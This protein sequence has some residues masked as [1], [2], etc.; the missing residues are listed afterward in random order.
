MSLFR[1]LT[2]TV[3]VLASAL[4][5]RAADE[6]APK[7]IRVLLVCGGCCHDY[8]RQKVLIAEGL[9]E[10]AHIEVTAVQQGGTATNSKIPLYEK[11]D[12]S[13]GY[14]LVI[15]DECFSDVNDSQYIAGILAPHKAGLPAV[16]LHC[17]MHCYRDGTDQWF[18]FCGVTSRMHGAGYPHEVLNRDPA[19]PIMK[20]FGPAWANPAGELYWIEK[21]WPTAH[22]LASSKN[23]EN[24]HDEVCVWTNQFE[25]G[26]VFGTTLG[27]H[28]E[29]VGSKAYLDM[30]TRG[31]L[32]AVD[33]LEPR[34]LK[35]AALNEPR[36]VP[37]NLAKGRPATASS[38][39]GGNGNFIRNAFD[40]N[41]STR[42]CAS[43]DHRPE[44]LQVDLGAP[45][46]L[47]AAR[48]DWE[49][50]GAYQFRLE[51]SKDGTTWTTIEDGSKNQHASPID[52]KFTSVNS[53]YVRV[54][55]L[56]G[57]GW[58]SL[59]EVELFGDKTE[60]IDPKT[61]AAKRDASYFAGVT[62]PEGYEAT[63]FAAPPAINYLVFVAAAPNGD[64]YASADRNGSIDREKVRGC[65]YRLRDLDG[66]GRA[67]EIK[68][69]VPDVDSPRG[70]VFDR[71]RVYLM[72]PPHLSAFIDKDGDGIADEQKV[73]VKNIAF[74]FK[75]RPADHTSNGV[76]LGIDGWL[77]LAI[78]D[79]GFL[80]AEGTDGRKL[81]LRG[82]GVVRVRPDGTGLELYSRGTRNIL[83]ASVDPLLN[84]FARDNTN[85]GG[86][87]D[88]RLHHFTGME[89][90]GYPR[91]FKNFND[92]TIAPLADYGG[93]SGCGGLYLSEPGFPNGDGDAL[94]TADWGRDRIYRHKMTPKGA[95]FAADQKE[96]M[97][98]P[99]V[100][101]LDVDALGH[102]YVSSW[103]GATFTFAGEEVGFILRVTPKGNK[104]DPLPD[105]PKLDEAG[106]V[107]ALDSPS[108]RRRL[109][110]QREL[111]SRTLN[112][113]TFE[114][115]IH[116]ASDGNK[117]L[118]VRVAALF[119]LK[120]G[121]AGRST[122][123]I[124]QLVSDPSIREYAL[125]ALTDRVDELKDVSGSS[126][127]AVLADQD[128]RVRRQAA[129]SL[130]RLGGTEHA[131]PLTALL[132]DR[133]PIVAHTAIQAL[134][135]LKAADA[136][137]TVVD[138]AEATALARTGAI[139]VLQSLHDP[140]I[141]DSL[142]RRLDAEKDSIRR[143]GLI[144]ALARLDHREGFWRGD[145][146]GTR[147]DTTG[148]YYQPEPW[149]ASPKIEAALMR[150]LQA[151]SGA[152]FGP[153]LRELD[154][155]KVQIQGEIEAVVARASGDPTL[156][157][158]AVEF[159]SRSRDIPASAV[160]F[161][162]KAAAPAKGRP[163]SLRSEATIALLNARGDASLRAAMVS[164]VDLEKNGRDKDEFRKARDAFLGSDRLDTHRRLFIT[165]IGTRDDPTTDW[166]YAALL[167]LSAEK[168]GRAEGRAEASKVIDAAWADPSRRV[169]ILHA[170]AIA[171]HQAFADR[172]LASLTD[173]D[174]I[175][176]AARD[177]AREL[178][179]DLNSDAPRPTGP[180]IETLS[181]ENVLATVVKTS[182][183]KATGE[184]LFTRMNCVNCHTVKQTE[185]P[186]GPYLGTIATTYKRRELAE[187]ILLPSKT[188]AQGFA[189]NVF[190]L[191]DGRTLTGFVTK[192]AADVVTVRDADGKEAVIPTSNIVER[193]KSTT[194][195][196]PE[197]LVKGITVG[198]FA[199]LLDYLESL[200][201]G[202]AAKK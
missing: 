179:L 114:G 36:V 155:N 109:A 156:V 70:L 151:S 88:I 76:T 135:S 37:V 79:F 50:S 120:Q 53:R 13:K 158:A 73:L 4:G 127:V 138:R 168:K 100:T 98:V 97:T 54:T 178:K 160:T 39:Q 133:D 45:T 15:H 30:L 18:K 136:C 43:S 149:K 186:K 113:S 147:P 142:I 22:P 77:Y 95:A 47:N 31:V 8:T 55:F 10:R 177:A 23:K 141:A 26:R 46:K 19:H 192:E 104:P 62:I 193:A 107:K 94:Y 60:V 14:D 59:N 152:D 38:E 169:Q 105:Y 139:R 157:F 96:F 65:V 163:V 20:E 92:E 72:H 69:F 167:T 176:S 24:G 130:S 85:D 34:Y 134:I 131:A 12:W 91:L 57:N 9:A 145:S 175:A 48:L 111:L 84:T 161:L 185:A 201:K 11:A 78:G 27:H 71:D 153:I 143:L 171:G 41:P 173:T 74:G 44:W 126:M 180:K 166:A 21:I 56:G 40:G 103:K 172:V 146:W 33:K 132:N 183:D 61:V 42:W 106:L 16:V 170:V 89:D 81:Q 51:G 115:L 159:L 58:G 124:F 182:G 162:A 1:R 25:K 195:V 6:P 165:L 191:E 184:R 122:A 198:E 137:F 68:R 99:R 32:W 110:A 2:L 144:G 101:D 83:E 17:A 187:A 3:V 64:L 117:P 164:L 123:P 66:D 154:R 93:G 35:T 90:H 121:F 148:P 75:D 5:A 52:L 129:V 197:G 63:V 140:K 49:T 102:M 194:S 200:S 118:P 108:D 112:E 174:V 181:L 119:T 86:G 87:W 125:R 80:Q 188:I 199:S 29:T 128:P 189:T 28:N 196:M 190:A 7:P 202:Q 67:D 150:A 116:L 82:G